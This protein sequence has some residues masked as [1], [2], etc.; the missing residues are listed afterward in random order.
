MQEYIDMMS[1][2]KLW[3]ISTD[4]AKWTKE[5]HVKGGIYQ[6][7]NFIMQEITKRCKQKNIEI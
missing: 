2:I 1:K 3:Q 5:Q 4:G 7:I 6:K